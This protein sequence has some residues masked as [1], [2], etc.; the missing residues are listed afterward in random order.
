MW[1]QSDP[2]PYQSNLPLRPRPSAF[3][4]PP[5]PETRHVQPHL[6]LDEWRC[7]PPLPQPSVNFVAP[8]EHRHATQVPHPPTA[9]R[10]IISTDNR[11]HMHTVNQSAAEI[12][13]P[14]KVFLSSALWNQTPNGQATLTFVQRRSHWHPLWDRPP[15]SLA[16]VPRWLPP[17]RRRPVLPFGK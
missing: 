15:H 3:C 11:V 9:L 12:R 7:M 16:A 2:Q 1:S 13:S 6:Q 4:L 8:T 17:H 14:H 5:F 10:P